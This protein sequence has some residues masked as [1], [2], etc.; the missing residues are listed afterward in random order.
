M[1]GVRIPLL[2]AGSAA[3]E[4]TS[5]P[6]DCTQLKSLVFYFTSTGDTTTGN[7]LIEEAD[8]DPLTEPPYSGTWSQ[9]V[10]ITTVSFTGGAQVAYHISP[11]EYAFLR[12]RINTGVSTG[13]I[14]AVAR[15][16]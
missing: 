2:P 15:A 10:S 12:V 4:T 6:I 8:W 11:N 9:V 1:A 3:D 14:K 16:S 13:S 5:Q 7:L